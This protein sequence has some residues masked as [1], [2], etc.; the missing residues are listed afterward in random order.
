MGS[1]TERVTQDTYSCV[2]GIESLHR[3]PV[4]WSYQGEASY[5]RSVVRAGRYPQRIL[6]NPKHQSGDFRC[7]WTVKLCNSIILVVHVCKQWPL[8]RHVCRW[9]TAPTNTPVSTFRWSIILGALGLISSLPVISGEVWQILHLHYC[10]GDFRCSW[11]VRLCNSIILVNVHVC[12]QWPLKRHVSRW[13]IAPTNT[14]VSTFRC[15]H[16]TRSA[17]SYFITA[18]HIR[19]GMT[20]T[21][22][23][24]YCIQRD[25]S[26]HVKRLKSAIAVFVFE[27][28]DLI[29]LCVSAIHARRT[30]CKNYVMISI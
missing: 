15:K 1:Y 26:Y 2:S 30:I 12:K 22:P 11:A 19:R 5:S 13:K 20:N 23:T 6:L 17:R 7:S 25:R 16:H 9:K 29:F 8:K 14:P 10:D 21:S 27:Q 28:S 3:L 4:E 24:L 18:R